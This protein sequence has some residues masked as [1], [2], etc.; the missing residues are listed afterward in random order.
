MGLFEKIFGKAP[1]HDV[2]LE[3]VFKEL[4]GY[5]PRFTTWG[6]EIYE[7]ELVRASINALSTHISKLNVETRGSARPSPG[8]SASPSAPARQY[9]PKS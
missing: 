5:T 6:G 2:K 8:I 1:K 9:F 4:N 7:S 3:T